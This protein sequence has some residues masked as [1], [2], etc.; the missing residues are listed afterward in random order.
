MADVSIEYDVIII[1]ATN[2]ELYFGIVLRTL[3]HAY[4]S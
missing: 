2:G 1:V 3:P 4:T